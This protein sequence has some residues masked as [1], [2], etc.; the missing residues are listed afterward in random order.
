M[1]FVAVGAGGPRVGTW[2]YISRPALRF[3]AA[4]ADREIIG[5]GSVRNGDGSPPSLIN[6][7]VNALFVFGKKR[8]A[9]AANCHDGGNLVSWDAHETSD[10]MA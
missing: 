4:G 1:P 5:V 2:L 8:K 9:T 6:L 7:S 10:E 3:A